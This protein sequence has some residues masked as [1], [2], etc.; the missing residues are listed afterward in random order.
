MPK[1]MTV[2]LVKKKISMPH[3][4]NHNACSGKVQNT[5]ATNLVL[6]SLI[7]HPDMTKKYK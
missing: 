5:G 7:T 4:Q 3:Y 1:L 2:F 6:H